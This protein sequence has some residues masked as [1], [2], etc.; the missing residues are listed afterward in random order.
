M[1]TK[2]LYQQDF[3]VLSNEADIHHRASLYSL[4]NYLQEA[5]RSHAEKLGWGV[6]LLRSQQQFWVL[7]RLII[8]VEAYP[9]PGQTIT[10]TTWPK[11]T[12][13]LFALRDFEVALGNKIIAR[14][15]SSWALL[16]LKSRR[17]NGLDAMNTIMFERVA[18][19]AIEAIPDKLPAPAVDARASYHTVT[20]SEL[21]LNG[22][23]NNTRYINWLLDTFDIA[24]HKK[25]SVASVQLNYLAEVF[26]DQTVS[27]SRQE[28]K[29]NTFL[30]QVT[31]TNNKVLFR[32][33]M[34]FT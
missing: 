30:F 23:V 12:D 22:H 7:T 34:T 18:I 17:P 24:F 16:D 20:Y 11:G 19:H 9:K 10:V 4:S 2:A 5:A 13:R 26:P 28:T 15:T 8:E 3:L 29:P 27:I 6:E 32:G 14:A 25:H 31:N 1:S 21:D 33:L